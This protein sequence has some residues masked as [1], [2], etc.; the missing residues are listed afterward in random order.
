MSTTASELSALQSIDDHTEHR[1]DETPSPSSVIF[2]TSYG[3]KP[4][5]TVIAEKALGEHWRVV[6]QNMQEQFD[7]IMTSYFPDQKPTDSMIGWGESELACAH[8]LVNSPPPNGFL[9]TD[10]GELQASLSQDAY[11]TKLI[12]TAC[13]AEWK[14]V[15]P[16]S[17][18]NHGLIKSSQ[19]RFQVEIPLGQDRQNP[20]IINCKCGCGEAKGINAAQKRVEELPE[21]QDVPGDGHD[22]SIISSSVQPSNKSETAHDDIASGLAK[23]DNTS[24]SGPTNPSLNMTQGLKDVGTSSGTT[25][26]K[27]LVQGYTVKEEESHLSFQISVKNTNK[28]ESSAEGD[29]R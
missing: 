29:K 11:Y 8:L 15:G 7:K 4:W 6:C 1:V 22:N 13:Q 3:H 20:K 9:A 5:T 28:V 14:A 25:D 21:A 27:E 23:T 17:N 18:S 26:S 24:L 19:L 12:R 2:D 10:R 16:P